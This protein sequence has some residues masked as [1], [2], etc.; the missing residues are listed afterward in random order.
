MTFLEAAAAV[1]RFLLRLNRPVQYTVI[2]ATVLHMI[3]VAI[4]NVPR[5]YVDYARFPLLSG[6]RQHDTYGTDTIGNSY[7]AKVVLNDPLDMYTKAR[8][9]QTPLE[10][11]TWTREE[12]APYPPAGL[13]TTAGLYAIGAATGIEFYGMVL[14]LAALFVALSLWYFLNTRWYLFPLLYLNFAYFGHRFVYV[15]DDSYLAMLVVVMIALVLARSRREA[16][17][18]LMALAITMKLSPAAYA[19]EMLTMRRGTAMIFA[20][21]LFAGFVLPYFIWDNYL[22][23]FTFHDQ[24]KGNIYDTVAA[25]LLVVPFTIVLW[26]VETRLGFD[27]RGSNRVV[28]RSV[29]DVRRHQDAGGP[30]SADRAPGAGQAG[31]PQHHGIHRP[32]ALRRGSGCV[33]ARVGALHHDRSALRIPGA[34]SAENR[35]GHDSRRR[36]ASAAH[37]QAAAVGAPTR[38]SVGVVRFETR[39]P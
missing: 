31:S 27:M 19:R 1:D 23:I 7:V 18:L 17:H 22:T 8:L 13:L 21:I 30:A 28:A 4:P 36:A 29:R 35:L 34:L 12:S 37:L 38:F 32:R 6:V 15:Q 2:A 24:V 33:P 14:L 3:A 11:A 16:S 39:R 20:A 5:A 26:Y 25:V 9:E 10:R